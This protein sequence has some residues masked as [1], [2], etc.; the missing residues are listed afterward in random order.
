MPLHTELLS[1]KEDKYQI[2]TI[3]YIGSVAPERGSILTLQSLQML[4]NKNRSVHWECIGATMSNNH[5][6]QLVY[7]TSKYGLDGINFR[8]FMLPDVG[9]SI[10][11]KCHIGLAILKPIPNFIESYPT[12]IFEYM[13]LGLP[14]ITSNFPLYRNIIEKERCGICIDPESREEL[15]NAIEWLLDHPY[16]AQLMGK[17]GRDAVTKRYNWDN[18]GQK[19][20]IFYKELLS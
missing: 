6:D 19:L 1:I 15:A 13:A 3:G 14:V 4:K 20:L 7:L 2:P 12:K 16:D 8:G 18:E 5:K 9:L 11:A 10:I 17:R